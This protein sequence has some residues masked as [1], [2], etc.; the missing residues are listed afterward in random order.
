MKILWYQQRSHGGYPR[1]I[2]KNRLP[3]VEI[4]ET[5]QII[6]MNR[7][8]FFSICVIFSPQ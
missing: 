4:M 7:F 3:K 2:E 8:I 1:I 5:A 6:N